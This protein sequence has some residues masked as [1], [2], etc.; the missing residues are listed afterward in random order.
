VGNLVAR[1]LQEKTYL[2]REKR[3]LIT[4]LESNPESTE[5]KLQLDKV[6]TDLDV[7]DRLLQ[8]RRKQKGP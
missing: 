6:I 5:M 4:K 1:F 2:E 7:L 3:N 8:K